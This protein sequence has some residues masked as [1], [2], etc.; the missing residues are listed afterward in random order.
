MPIKRIDGN[1]TGLKAN[2]MHRLEHIYRRKVP[3]QQIV[4][5][6]PKAKLCMI[7]ATG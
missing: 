7:P 1:M 6:G 3:A 2:Q 4:T 5:H